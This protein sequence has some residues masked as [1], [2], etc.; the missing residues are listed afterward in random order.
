MPQN[1]FNDDNVFQDNE[2]SILYYIAGYIGKCLAHEKC[3]DFNE[4]FTPGK[5]PLQVSFESNGDQPSDSYT[6]AKE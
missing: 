5:V 1:P 4:L 3:D 6:T 2:K